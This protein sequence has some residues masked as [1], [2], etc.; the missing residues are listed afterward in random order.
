M[1]HINHFSHKNHPFKVINFEKII[2]ASFDS[3]DK[4]NQNCLVVM[5][6]KNPYQVALHI[7]T[8]N[9]TTFHKACA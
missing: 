4:K 6:V 3:C 1:E 8:S 7:V 5:D 2:C 9:V